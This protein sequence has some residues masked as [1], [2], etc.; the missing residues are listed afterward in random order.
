LISFTNEEKYRKMV[1]GD[2]MKEIAIFFI[3]IYQSIPLSSHKSC[4]FQPTCSNYAIE[5]LRTHGFFKGSYL[6]FKRLLRCNPWG[7][8]GYDPVPPRRKK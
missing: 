6:A 5:A 1:L 4:R 3:K 7:P 8:F 2:Y